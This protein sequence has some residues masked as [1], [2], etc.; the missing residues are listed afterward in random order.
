MAPLGYFWN[1]RLSQRKT[2]FLCPESPDR[3]MVLSP[4]IFASLGSN[5]K[6]CEFESRGASILQLAHDS[7][8]IKTVEAAYSNGLRFLDS[9]ETRVTSNIFEQALLSASAGCEAIDQILSKKIASAFCAIRPPGHHANQLRAMGFCVFNNL[10]IAARYAQTYH[11]IGSIMIVDWDVHPG[12]GTQEIFWDDPTVFTLSFHQED[13]FPEAGKVQLIGKG[14][15]KGFNRNIA[16]PAN[17]SSDS[18]LKIFREVVSE[19]TQSFRPELLLIGAG[20]DSHVRDPLGSMNLVEEDFSRMTKIL[21]EI[22][23]PSTSG[24]SLSL[25]EGGY[26][27]LAL[28][29]CV[30][31]H[32]KALAGIA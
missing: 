6:I 2:G 5:I 31:T 28:K 26:N 23:Q 10:A 14:K 9:G 1:E 3:Y 17:I 32:C 21:L 19:V 20:F 16:L 24:K 4:S 25:L 13:L 15:G 22:T 30:V 27:I 29:K 12:N 7:E 11:G 18:Y 8:Y